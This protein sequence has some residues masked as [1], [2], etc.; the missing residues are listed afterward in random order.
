MIFAHNHNRPRIW[1]RSC[2]GRSVR[3]GIYATVSCRPRGLQTLV[4]V[5][6]IGRR[7]VEDAGVIPS[8]INCRAI[9][10]QR[11]TNTRLPLVA[12]TGQL[13][14]ARRM[15]VLNFHWPL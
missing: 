15:E 7:T 12:A 5:E 1:A 11:I 8:R 3:I 10:A 13:D 9:C 4:V 14:N 6:E 2:L